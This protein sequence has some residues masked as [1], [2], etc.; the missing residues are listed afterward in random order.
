MGREARVDVG[1]EIYHILNR[2]AGRVCIFNEP[3]DYR[4]FINLLYEAKE[5]VDVRIISFVIMPNHWHLQ[6]WLKNDG[7]MQLFMHWLTNTHTHQVREETDTVGHG[8]I[9]QGRYKS[10]ITQS[11]NHLLT[12]LK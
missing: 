8:P 5:Y 6:I 2:A 7:D 4:R 3:G 1:G 11:D 10:F 9:Y 12:V